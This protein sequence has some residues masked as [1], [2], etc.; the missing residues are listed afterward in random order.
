VS[1]A[2]SPWG[3]DLVVVRDGD[4]VVATCTLRAAHEGAP[5]RSHGGV[6]AA[7]FDDVFG[8]VLGL[9]AT[10][11]FT[12]ELGVRYVGPTPLH[13]PLEFRARLAGRER[14]KLFLTAEA[15]SAGQVFATAT[16]TF[17]MVE[18]FG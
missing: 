1:G 14:R 4:E 6:T 15:S 12:G 10:V 17:V 5:G 16:S 9:H 2:A 7:I 13:V 3:V 8:F 11:A 18:S